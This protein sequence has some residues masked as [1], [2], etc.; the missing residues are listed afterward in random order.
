MRPTDAFQTRESENRQTGTAASATPDPVFGPADPIH[1]HGL[2]RTVSWASRERLR[3]YWYRLRLT[4]AEMN[5]ASR[6]MVELQAPW[7]SDDRPAAAQSS[8]AAATRR[9]GGS[10][11]RSH[12]ASCYGPKVR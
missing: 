1:R 6:R 10:S 4:M 8:P 11:S 7:I 3:W 2:E 9:G 12:R 5:Y